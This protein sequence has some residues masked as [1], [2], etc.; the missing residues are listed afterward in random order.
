MK[1]IGLYIALI[2]VVLALSYGSWRLER[3]AHYKFG[4]QSQVQ[5]EIQPLVKRISVLEQRVSAIE[6]NAKK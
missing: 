3:W 5:S 6:N 1:T 2:A 4:Y